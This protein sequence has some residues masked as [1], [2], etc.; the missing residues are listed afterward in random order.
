MD[1][2][3]ILVLHR[4]GN[5]KF[6]AHFLRQ[7]VFALKNCLPEH[8]YIYHDT[9]LPLPGYVRDTHFDAIIL[10]VT[11]LCVRWLPVAVFAGIKEEYDFVKHSDSTKIA[12]PQD[13]YDCSELLDGWM[14]EWGID[15]VFSVISSHWDVLYPQYNRVGSIKLGYT[16]YVDETLLSTEQ[17]P[18]S[19]RSVDIGYRARKLPPYFGRIGETKWTIGRDVDR[20]GKRAGLS[21]DIVLGEQGTLY[22]RAWIEFIANSKFMLGSN[23]GSSL[24]DPRGD[25]QQRVR[26]YLGKRPEARFEEVEEWCFKGLDQQYSFTAISPRVLEAALLS[27]CQILVEG[28]YSGIVQPWEHYIPVRSDASDF[29]QV[30]HAMRDQHL[31][32]RLIRNCREAILDTE[33]LRYRHTARTVTELISTHN[34]RKRAKSSFDAVGK[35]A[36]RYEQEMPKKYADHWRRQAF[37]GKLVRVLDRSPAV[38]RMIRS[39][40]SRVRS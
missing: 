7:H 21:T 1:K 20:H 2:L 3:N 26:E 25:I 8:N 16:G 18:F 33:G 36:Q 40:W 23:S 35:I 9:T 15:V 12:F 31:V 14:C 17:K 6:V 13:E 37:R 24:L 30:L 5:P 10:D 28:E 34:V 32:D 19:R 27:S 38:S 11:F 22:G 39:A 4:L 29:P